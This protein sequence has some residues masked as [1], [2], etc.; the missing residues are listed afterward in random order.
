MNSIHS[1]LHNLANALEQ[2]EASRTSHAS[3]L[4]DIAETLDSEVRALRALSGL[5]NG[6]DNNDGARLNELPYLIDPIIEREVELIDK[7]HALS[8][9]QRQ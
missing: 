5:F 1:Q 3:Q 8:Q 4:G 7:I 9:A 6:Q 2:S